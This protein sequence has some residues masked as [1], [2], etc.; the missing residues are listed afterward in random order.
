[1][2][3][4]AIAGLQLALSNGAN[5]AS[6]ADEVASVKRRFP[7]VDLVVLSELCA[8]GTNPEF[9]ERLPGPTE[10]EF[11]RIAQENAVWLIPGS[12]FERE[13]GRIYNTTPVIDPS[14]KIV[15]RYRK[16]F[17][18]YP[19]EEGV[20][21]GDSFCVA[22]VAGTAQIGI[23][24]CYDIWFPEAARSLVWLGAEVI[25]NPSLTNTI[26]RDVELAL[27]RAAAATNQCYV[28]NVN[29]AGS[30]GYGRSIVCGPGGEVLHQAGAGREIIVLELNLDQVQRARE[31]GWNGLGQVLK[32]FRDRPK[33]YPPYREGARSAAL[34]SLGPLVT[35]PLRKGET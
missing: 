21:G 30:Q 15:A 28:F 18:F 7:W 16:M 2:R 34:D 25:I 35:A 13:A 9:A 5:V 29:G 23:L 12:I 10:R 17:P 22:A 32:S 14:G 24:N 31:R 1:V 11:A 27:V 8:H 3:T 19:Y 6:L 33:N 20:T 26:D 4:L